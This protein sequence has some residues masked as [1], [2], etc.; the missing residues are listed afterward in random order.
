MNVIDIDT[1]KTVDSHIHYLK[2][3]EGRA[4]LMDKKSQIVRHHITFSIEYGALGEK[5]ILVDFPE[6]PDLPVE[7]LIP[8][9]LKRIIELDK[10][11]ILA[12]L[13]N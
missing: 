2:K 8:K 13:K 3:Y 11:G 7:S 10:S 6:K 4:I 5:N 1:I 12:N 9:I